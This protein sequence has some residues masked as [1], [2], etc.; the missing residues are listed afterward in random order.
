MRRRVVR[1]SFVVV[2]LAAM[3]LSI[4]G[5]G[6]QAAG[7]APTQRVI[8]ISRDRGVSSFPHGSGTVGRHDGVQSPELAP[9]AR[10]EEADRSESPRFTSSQAA[11]RSP[12]G[13]P[14]VQPTAVSGG[15]SPTSFNGINSFEERYVASGGNQFSVTPPDQALC[16]GNGFVLEAVNDALRIYR[17]NG[18]PVTDP[19]GLNAFFGYPP[20]IN[21]TTFE[22]GPFPTD[23]VCLYDHQYNRWYV[24][25]LTLDTKP[26]TGALTGKNRLDIAV[27]ATADPTAGWA[28]YHIAAQNDGTN[29]T[30]THPDCPCIGDF[31]HIGMDQYGFYVTTNEYPF[32]G[33][34]RFGTGYNGV[35]LYAISKF[36]LAQSSPRL[37]VVHIDVRRTDDGTPSFT[38]WPANVAGTQFDTSAGG[39]EWFLQ[40]NATEEQGDE[41]RMGHTITAWRL[42]N[43]SSLD[44]GNPELELG[45]KTLESEEYGQ[46][47]L[48]EQRYGPTP[49]RDCLI[50][51]CLPG[52]G[53]SRNEVEGSLDSSDGRMLTAWW[54]NNRLYGA[55]D[56]IASVNGN[57]KA[58]VAYFVVKTDEPRADVKIVNQGYVAVD[59]N[60]AIYPSIAT[61]DSGQGVMALNVVGSRYYPSA[62]YIHIDETGAHGPILMA[63]EG[64]GPDDEFCQYIYYGCGNPIRPRWGDYSAATVY[65]GNI[66]IAQE[67]IGNRCT[68]R[69]YQNDPTCGATRGV[70]FNWNTRIT[71]V[72]P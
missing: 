61:L 20:V 46:P 44:S 7:S 3:G 54:A 30:P 55:L 13:V 63:K 24:L 28:F 45:S 56:T 22:F 42:S 64:I 17:T 34:G 6:A 72:A 38:M 62:A 14:R 4:P 18:R 51:E 27:S 35:Q 48:S 25:I 11:Q 31:P 58:A 39:V 66:W 67:Y 59:D 71:K 53:P 19:I 57:L 23:P 49:L 15:D 65:N 2:L 68:F 29:G 8:T 60:N 1:S 37:Q 16:V 12:F 32:S 5:S 43:T 26:K 70:L 10:A 40:S 52:V 9:A 36:A 33:P 21:R 41:D 69:Q 50:V 47:P